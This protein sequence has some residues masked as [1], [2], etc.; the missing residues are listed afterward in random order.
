V[1]FLATGG[2]A[3]FLTASQHYYHMH[4]QHKFS[5]QAFASMAFEQGADGASVLSSC[6]SYSSMPALVDV[7][8]GE[9]H[10]EPEYI[11]N[12]CSCGVWD[13]NTRGDGDTTRGDGDTT[14][15]DGEETGGPPRRGHD[16]H[17]GV[18]TANWGGH[19]GDDYLENHMNEDLKK[20]V[21]QVIVIQEADITHGGGATMVAQT[22]DTNH[23]EAVRKRFIELVLDYFNVTKT[24]ALSLLIEKEKQRVLG[25][26]PA[27]VI[28]AARVVVG[29]FNMVVDSESESAVAE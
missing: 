11:G 10:V 24:N 9:E 3:F 4:D 12:A 27:L 20:T 7:H 22:I 19:W 16:G 15:G 6:S 17:F 1:F 21:C 18:L 14:R 29:V 26:V 2:G 25:V 8:T 5:A 28:P 13:D 23:H